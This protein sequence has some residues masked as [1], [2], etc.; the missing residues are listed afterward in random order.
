MWRIARALIIVVA[1]AGLPQSVLAGERMPELEKFFGSYEGKTISDASKGLST[2]DL[3]IEIKPY[4][5]EGFTVSWTTVLKKADG[6][7]KT[8][9][10]KISF[11]DTPREGIFG[12]AMRRNSF[13]HAVPLNPLKG[14][15]YVWASIVGEVMVMHALHIGQDGGYEIQQ[16][17]RTLTK[18]GLSTKFERVR[19]GKMLNV[20]TGELKKVK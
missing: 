5:D 11:V 17:T 6:T 16:H 10:Y 4:K 19:N 20:I 18:D 9:S 15:P 1:I 13:G 2:R 14:E 8:K 12:S 7:D 3:N